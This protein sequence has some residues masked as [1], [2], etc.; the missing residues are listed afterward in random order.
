M[1]YIP[2]IPAL[3]FGGILLSSFS[4]P[5]VPSPERERL[6]R[7]YRL[8][9]IYE[10][11]SDSIRPDTVRSLLLLRQAAEGGLPEAEN[12]LG[13][14]Y[15]TGKLT[16]AQPD[17]A[18]FWLKKAADDGFST[19]AANIGFMYAEGV[20]VEKNMENAILWLS[21]AAAQDN[22]AAET[23]LADLLLRDKHATADTL[24]AADLY[25]RAARHGFP[26]ADFKL[27]HLMRP[28]WE[29]L[30]SDSLLSLARKHYTGSLP[31]S[32]VT[33]LKIILSRKDDPATHVQADASTLLANALAHGRGIGYDHAASDAMFLK[34]ALLGNQEARSILS[35]SLEI[36]PD[37]LSTPESRQVLKEYFGENPIPR[38]IYS[39]SYWRI[40]DLQ[41]KERD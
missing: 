6:L 32:G 10:R 15:M 24:A 37:M 1:K 12:Y 14:V 38:E 7:L 9:E 22:P 16:A 31:Y 18:L 40:D 21:K 30:Q 8:S 33:L 25:E 36:F 41:V 3:L 5:P 27:S 13:F 17:S 35:E 29:T 11:G 28:L 39:P 19:A 23:Q 34:G 20:G 26:T 2:L 4:T